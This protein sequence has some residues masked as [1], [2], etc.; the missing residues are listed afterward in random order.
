MKVHTLTVGEL[1]TN[2][3]ILEQEGVAV[4]VDPGAEPERFLE[5]VSAG[6]LNVAAILI[7]H[8]HADHIGAVAELRKAWPDAP[9]ICHLIDAPMLNS[10]ELNL[11][12]FTGSKLRVGEPDRFVE[13]GEELVFGPIHLVTFCI[14]GHTPGQVAFF[15]KTAGVFAGDTLFAGSIGRSDFPGGDG[16]ALIKAIR[17]QLLTLPEKTVVYPGHGPSTTIGEEKRSNP[18]LQA[19]FSLESEDFF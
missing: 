18:F 2:G 5:V 7:T 12:L 19:G 11:S 6:K 15:E 4:V 13:C 1:E 16:F 9:V 14:P 17:E 10:P 8:G 3:Y